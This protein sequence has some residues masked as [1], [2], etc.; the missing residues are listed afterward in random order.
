MTTYEPGT[1][2]TV[3]EVL[4][5]AEWASWPERVLS[6]DGSVLATVQPDG[7]GLTFPPHPVPHP[8]GHL[9]A[10]SGTT[11]L[12]L[13]RVE[14]WYSVW[15][16]FDAS[17]FVSW[18]VNFETPV[19]RRPGAVEVNDLQ[20]DIVIPAGE[21]WRWKDVQDLGPSLASGRITQ[22]E[23]IRVLDAAAEVAALLD[24]DERW[25]SPWDGWTPDSLGH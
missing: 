3:R 4:H 14:E 1:E 11:V 23:L 7:T 6:D 10:W 24:R 21:P 20:L 16:F 22:D 5:G 25:W 15:K 2:V 18:Y 19:V 12:K 8:W 17:G 9:D 13:R